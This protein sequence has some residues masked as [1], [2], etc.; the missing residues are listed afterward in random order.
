MGR[1]GGVHHSKQT[2][3]HFIDQ[4]EYTLHNSEYNNNNDDDDDLNETGNG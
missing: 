4:I 1:E 3:I 2:I